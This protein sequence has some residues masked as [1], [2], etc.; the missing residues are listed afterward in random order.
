MYTKR[1]AHRVS[2]QDPDTLACLAA[3][4]AACGEFE[5]AIS[6][7]EKALHMA[8]DK[9]HKVLVSEITEHLRFYHQGRRFQED[10][11]QKY[12]SNVIRWQEI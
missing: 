1:A 6:V 12:Q 4:W 3:A 11:Y 9:H 10:P 2:H 8:T 7:A 5:Y